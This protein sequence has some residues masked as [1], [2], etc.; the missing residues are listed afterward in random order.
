VLIRA[1]LK[2]CGGSQ[3]LLLRATRE[4]KIKLTQFSRSAAHHHPRRLLVLRERINDKE[5][6]LF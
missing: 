6:R 2:L 3:R 4:R 5:K 1:I